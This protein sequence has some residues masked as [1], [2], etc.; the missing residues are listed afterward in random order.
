MCLSF[1]PLVLF[2]IL[3]QRHMVEFL[4]TL[5]GKTKEITIISIT[6]SIDAFCLFMLKLEPNFWTVMLPN[7]FLTKNLVIF[8]LSIK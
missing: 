6:S 4:G 2:T 1:A 7:S 8:R 5:S 3:M